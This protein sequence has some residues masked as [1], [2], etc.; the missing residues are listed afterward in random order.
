M[1]PRLPLPCTMVR[2][3]DGGSPPWAVEAGPLLA[4]MRAR[5]WRRT[6]RDTGWYQEWREPDS[7]D[8]AEEYTA[9]CRAVAPHLVEDQDVPAR[10]LR[11]RPDLGSGI[12]TLTSE[13]QE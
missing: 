5:G 10:V 6:W 3:H 12:W 9:L 11:A 7:E 1:I 8:G 13:V 2:V 4:Q